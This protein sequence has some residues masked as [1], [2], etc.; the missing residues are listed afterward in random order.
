MD[1]INILLVGVGGQGI[2]TLSRMI[3][4]TAMIGGL[5]VLISEVH[6][7]SQRGG[8]VVVHLKAGEKVYSPL[9]PR[10]DADWIVGLEA[11]ETYRHINYASSETRILMDNRVIPPP[12]SSEESPDKS[13]LIREIEKFVSE[14]YVVPAHE[15]SLNIGNPILAN[16]ILFGGLARVNILGLDKELYLKAL[17]ESVPGKFLEM[18][19]KAFEEGYKYLKL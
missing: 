5:D 12:L 16:T 13:M 9:I 14:V 3:G 8:S 1:I 15:L 7:M 10:H 6:G 18:N 19:L 11:I 4:H 17:E 2:L